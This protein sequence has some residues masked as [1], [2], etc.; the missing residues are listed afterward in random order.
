MAYEDPSPSIRDE[1]HDNRGW[2]IALGILLIVLGVIAFFNLLIATVASVYYVGILMIIGAIA[3]L[4]LAFRVKGW[5]RV[6]L[7]V[8]GAILYGLA[9][10][11]AFMNPL[12]ASSVLT[13]M[14]AVFLIA[15]GVLRIIVALR[16][17][18]RPNWGWV[19]AMGILSII[20][21]LIVLAGWPVNS[22]WILGLFLAADLIGQG[23]SWLFVG[24]GLGRR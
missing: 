10:I 18:P 5:G 11:F 20:V 22:L 1:L 6:T 19:L 7:M 12:L 24:I 9:G 17:R 14:L 13:L 4:V 21:A 23:F 15:S 8:L 3:Q 2:L 16:E